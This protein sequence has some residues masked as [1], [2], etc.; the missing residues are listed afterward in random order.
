MR[1]QGPDDLT[2]VCHGVWRTWAAPL[3]IAA[4]ARSLLIPTLTPTHHPHSQASSPHTNQPSQVGRQPRAPR[5][6]AA[7]PAWGSPLG[8]TWSRQGRAAR[9]GALLGP[10]RPACASTMPGPKLGRSGPGC[11]APGPWGAPQRALSPGRAGEPPAPTP[12]TPTRRRAPPLARA[13]DSTRT[14]APNPD[15]PLP[16]PPSSCPR[17]PHK[18]TPHHGAVPEHLP[19]PVHHRPRGPGRRRCGGRQRRR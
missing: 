17:R 6:A 4:P 1:R 7:C 14:Q 13:P 16:P 11:P 10:I 18:P 3:F 19:Q 12:P 9:R 15:Q 8:C 5:A 2:P